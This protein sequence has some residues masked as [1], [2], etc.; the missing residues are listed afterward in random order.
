LREL[1][2][3]VAAPEDAARVSAVLAASY[4]TLWQGAYEPDALA[5]VLPLVSRARPE[6]LASGRYFLALRGEALVAVGGWSLEDPASG[7]VV[8]GQGHVRHFATH[9][10]HLRQG[11]AGLILRRCLAEA[12][13]AGVA[14]MMCLASLPSE[15]FYAAHGFS[16][17]RREETRIGG[18][19]LLPSLLMRR[20]A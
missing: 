4:G 11:A 9:P 19:F 18:R 15:G 13:A 12:E 20:V 17:L 6:L 14:E 7:A 8:P 1:T 3:R 5:A 2:L 10:D 16:T